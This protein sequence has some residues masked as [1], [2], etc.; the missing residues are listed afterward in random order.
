M[1][2]LGVLVI[3]KILMALPGISER[4]K[5]SEVIAKRRKAEENSEIIVEVL[6]RTLKTCRAK[7]LGSGKE[8]F[9]KRDSA[10]E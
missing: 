1:M 3:Y 8:H 5:H 6:D 9:G 4:S 10:G 2:S 7:G